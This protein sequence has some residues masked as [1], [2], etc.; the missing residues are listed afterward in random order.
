MKMNLRCESI[1]RG[2][3]APSFLK[4]ETPL[5]VWPCTSNR[6]HNFRSLS[7]NLR[8]LANLLESQKLAILGEFEPGGIL[9]TTETRDTRRDEIFIQ[10]PEAYRHQTI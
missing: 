10:S 3:I 4:P 6:C 2:R 1:G 8:K 5:T 7:G 9:A